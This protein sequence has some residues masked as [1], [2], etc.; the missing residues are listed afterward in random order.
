MAF[1]PN[2]KFEYVDGI[3]TCPDCGATLVDSLEDISDDDETA[4]TEELSE[5]VMESF[6]SDDLSDADKEEL[7]SQIKEAAKAPTYKSMAEQYSENKSGA[8]VL[9]FCGAI[10]LLVLI[11]NG[12]GVFNFP[13]SG[14]SLIL[15]DSVMGA[16]FLIFLVF[17]KVSFSKMKALEPEVREEKR[18]IEE[19]LTYIRK[20]KDE[21]F[22]ETVDSDV[23][24][25]TLY[26]EQC[27]RLVKD[28]EENFTDLEP[29][30]A[31]YVVD[32]FAGDILD[33]D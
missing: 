22:F 7:L 15:V 13:L 9:I 8:S 3:D 25:E 23:E 17:G 12:V 31:F 16:L 21:G 33:E 6:T 10:G 28:I 27:E 18:K 14:L 5:G 11:L 19:L 2:C 24:K 30:F 20:K 29:G 1:C 32:R 4:A 26:L